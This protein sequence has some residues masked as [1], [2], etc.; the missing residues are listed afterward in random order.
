[1]EKKSRKLK[2]VHSERLADNLHSEIELWNEMYPNKS[3]SFFDIMVDYQKK[4]A[5]DIV[6]T[7][8]ISTIK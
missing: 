5:P 6:L 3:I 4:Y 1:M 7:A 8:K 2:D